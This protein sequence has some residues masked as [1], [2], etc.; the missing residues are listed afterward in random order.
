MNIYQSLYDLLNTYLYG[1][2]ATQADSTELCCTL[3]ASI[4][5]IAMVAIPFAICYKLI[6]KIGGMI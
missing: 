4:G 1:G 3:L 6:T 5:T 2:I